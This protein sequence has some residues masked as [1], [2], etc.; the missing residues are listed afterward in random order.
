MGIVGESLEDFP[1]IV[2]RI[3]KILIAFALTMFGTTSSS[4]LDTGNRT[5]YNLNVLA[6]RRVFK[7]RR[8]MLCQCLE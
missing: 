7:E 2:W 4:V 5:L 6:L 3:L 1:V 8:K